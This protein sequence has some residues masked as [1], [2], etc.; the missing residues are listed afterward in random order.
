K[1]PITV[2]L[3]D[4]DF[5]KLYNDCYGHQGGDECLKKT[6]ETISGIPKRPGDLTAR[7][8]G[9]EF[10]VILPNT[11]SQGGF[12]VAETIRAAVISLAVPHLKSETESIVTLSLGVASVIPDKELTQENLISMADRALYEAKHKGRNRTVVFKDNKA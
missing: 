9:E 4:I 7:Y 1:S 11:D 5:F 2:I 10:A 3:I 8:G 6:A 12:T